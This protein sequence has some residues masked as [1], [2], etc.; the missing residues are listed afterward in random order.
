[1]F[2]ELKNIKLNLRSRLAKATLLVGALILSLVAL[3]ITNL[4]HADDAEVEKP[5]VSITMSP[6]KSVINDL[7]PG[8]KHSGEFKIINTGKKAFDFTV[9]ISPYS[10][11]SSKYDNNYNR[12]TNYT[13][14]SRW[15][16]F[17]KTSYHLES[18]ES[19]MVSYSI[20]IPTDI[21]AGGQ[22]AV[23]FAETSGDESPED[24]A[25][26]TMQRVGMLVY[27]HLE[28]DTRIEG[29][30]E[31]Q[32]I[33]KF[34][35]NPPIYATSLVK[36]TGNTDFDV[37]YNLKIN[38]LFGKEVYKGDRVHAVLPETSREVEQD[39]E[40]TPKLGIFKVTQD[41]TLFEK[42]YTMKKTVFVCP[43]WLL[44][45][46]IAILVILVTIIVQK[47]RNRSKKASKK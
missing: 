47:I 30:L 36:N 10:V 6:A 42:V 17:D 44:I 43:I 46:I 33:K 18:D 9:S 3:N 45:T 14:I 1:M 40:E 16:T 32:E 2:K 8:A 19:V 25:I 22:Y 39:W 21:P 35:F 5:E 41:I 27:A 23:I 34:F 38:S 11:N 37:T 29:I 28:G 13:Q 20:N 31:S 26:S 12:E 15:V 7:G 24:S 4:A